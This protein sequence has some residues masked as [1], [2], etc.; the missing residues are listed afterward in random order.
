MNGGR[1]GWLVRA[2]RLLNLLFLVLV[3]VLLWRLAM[4]LQWHEVSQAVGA[5]SATTLLLALGATV[6]SFALYSSY[7]LL[8][9]HY[10][11]H[12]LPTRQVLALGF[13]VYAFNLNLSAWV[14]AIALRYRLYSRLGLEV[15]TITRIL[16]FSLATNW[17]GYLLLAGV[18]FALEL[19][20]LPDHWT[21]S[22]SGLRMVGGA[23]LAVAAAYL[24]AC[25]FAKRRTWRWCNQ[26]LELP[27]TTMALIQAALSSLNWMLPALVVFLLL[28]VGA[29]YPQV[30]GIM[31]ISSIAGIITHIPA[32]LGVLEAVFIT[33][34]QH[35][36]GKGAV[37]AA[38]LGYRAI[39][40]LLPLALASM[41]YLVLERRAKALRQ[42]RQRA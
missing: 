40:L 6:L 8:A 15:G 27:D 39:Y 22:S 37:L 33:L 35:Q 26:C 2:R 9:G 29:S 30:L 24:L 31:L 4:N 42:Q 7:D 10:V 28:P 19:V 1:H 23:L 16:S 17:L 14:G 3:P 5:Y 20:R 18:L 38:L 36:L 13:V 41:V 11:R 25:R 34:L 21:L 12:S 32:G